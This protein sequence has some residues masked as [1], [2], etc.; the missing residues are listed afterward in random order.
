MPEPPM[1]RSQ[2]IVQAA[3]IVFAAVPPQDSK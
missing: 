3:Q 2:K 1:E